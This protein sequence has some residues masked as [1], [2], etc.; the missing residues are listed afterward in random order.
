[1]G[2]HALLSASSSKRWM[3]C[4][5]SAR[6][7]EQFEESESIYAAEGTAAHALAEHKIRKYLKM[8]SKKPKT[9]FDSDEMDEYT[10][11]YVSYVIEIIEKVKQTCKDP[12]ILVEAHLDYS[13]YV[14]EGFGTGDIVIAADNTLYII[15]LKYGKG[16]AVDAEWNSQMML[17]SLGALE[18]FDAIYDIKKV[19]MTI[20]QPRLES[21]ST[22]EI[23]ADDLK[24]WANETLRPRADLAI[25]GEG[26]FI[27]GSWCR[28]CK[29]KNKCRA[30]ADSF[31]E[32][33]KMEFKPP[34]LLTDDEI[35]EVLSIADELSKWAQDVY[36][37]AQDEAINHAK[38]WNG[39]KLV[40]GRSNRK[41]SNEDEV[42]KAAKNAGYIDIFK[43]TLIGI[44]EMEKL[45]GKKNFNEILGNLIYKP[46]GKV[47][48]VGESDKRQAINKT[49]A[50][51]EFQEE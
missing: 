51:A 13:C 25:K 23:I 2:K 44:S 3:N 45:M 21:I 36:A 18:L 47:T 5:P 38:Q 34:A 31:L 40:E 27:P 11:E 4:T 19:S 29:A 9:E 15:D 26:E 6:L 42:V 48:L 22:W 16:I 12:I 8:R 46:Q 35:S 43:N 17:Y 41:Y 37:Y 32:L 33:A 39:F 28:F 24:L 20:H 10:D 50:E 7:E 49:T 14:S 1:M 30:R